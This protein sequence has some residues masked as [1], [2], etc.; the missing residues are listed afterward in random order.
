MAQNIAIYAA[1]WKIN[2]IDGSVK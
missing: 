1:M 2:W